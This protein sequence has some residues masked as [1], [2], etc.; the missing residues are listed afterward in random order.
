MPPRRRIG[1][2]LTAALPSAHVEASA[3]VTIAA[4]PADVWAVLVD[5]EAW[6]TWTASMRSIRRLADGPLA[7]GSTVEIRQPGFPKARWE[8]TDLRDGQ[9]FTW[10]NRSPGVHSI[11]HHELEAHDG[12]TVVTL[13]L[14]QTGPLAGVLGALTG[15]RT[16]RFVDVEA[17]GLRRRCKAG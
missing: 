3:T 14:T 16:R 11:G 6:P 10:E 4:P 5:V 2:E 7:V 15:R 17:D 8:V 1:P 9:G 13:R 12:G